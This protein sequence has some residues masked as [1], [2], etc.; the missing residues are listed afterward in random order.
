MGGL[1][2]DDNVGD[3]LQYGHLISNSCRNGLQ[4]KRA[5]LLVMEGDRS[6]SRFQG[7]ISIQFVVERELRTK[8]HCSL[9]VVKCVWRRKRTGWGTISVWDANNKPNCKKARSSVARSPS[10]PCDAADFPFHSL[11]TDLFT[12]SP[13]PS[14]SSLLVFIWLFHPIQLRLGLSGFLLHLLH[15]QMSLPNEMHSL[16][17]FDY[18]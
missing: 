13:P 3:N 10:F 16:D 2:L 5:E 15:Y 4:I 8:I 1:L 9:G 12:L 11:E 17:A 6:F 14:F 7:K 18:Y